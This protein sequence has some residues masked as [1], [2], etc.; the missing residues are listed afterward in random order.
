V[1]FTTGTCTS[2]LLGAAPAPQPQASLWGQ[3]ALRLITIRYN[4]RAA[5]TVGNAQ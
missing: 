4:K 1:W 5:A 3:D 2:S